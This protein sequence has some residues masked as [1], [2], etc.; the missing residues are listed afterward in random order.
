MTWIL[1]DDGFLEV[2]GYVMNKLIGRVKNGPA[3]L[4]SEL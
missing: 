2:T 4:L 3:F 1:I